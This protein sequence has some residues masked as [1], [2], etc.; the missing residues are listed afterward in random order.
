MSA[1]IDRRLAL[2]G[3]ACA[4]AA[5]PLPAGARDAASQ[6]ISEMVRTMAER[7]AARSYAPPLP[8][9]ERDALKGLAYDQYRDIRF[10]PSAALWR[11]DAIGH[12]VQFFPLGWLYEQPVE[13]KVV[14]KGEIVP[15]RASADLFDIG[16]L[17]AAA[18]EPATRGFSGFRLHAALNRP[19]YLDEYLVF[20]GA[21]YLRAVAR[22]QSYGLS[23]R[24]LSID[25]AR[26]SGEEFPAFRAFWIEKP[27]RGSDAVVVHALLDSPSVTGAYTFLV[28]P[29]A[30]TTMDVTASLFARRPLEHVGIAPLTSMYLHGP[31]QRR[32]A[33][34]FRPAV[35]DSDGLAILGGTGEQVWRPLVNPRT[36]QA[37]AFTATDPRGF[38]LMQRERRFR[39]FEDIEARYD[40]R[41]S[42]WVEPI[43]NWGPGSVDLIEIPTEEEIHDN[44]AVAWR[45]HAPLLPGAPRTYAYRLHWTSTQPGPAPVMVVNRTLTGGGK[46]GPRF[47]IDFGGKWSSELPRLD[48]K[49]SAGTVTHPVLQPLPDGDGMR[50]TFVLATG[51]AALSEL[52]AVLTSGG[53]QVSETWLYRWTR[54]G[55]A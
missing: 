11:P 29:G 23:A 1:Q 14:D 46:G 37:S 35:H 33:N 27:A 17:A 8:L 39:A 30:T 49:A 42:C 5:G 50:A 54:S 48:V 44:I 40:L 24:G 15:V 45:P 9:P 55:T 3:M 38:G 16:S 51:S 28:R 41:P 25:T 20:Q 52:R 36:L 12:E 31:A 6:S 10:R 4:A 26:P 47:V 43:G 34:D 22:G 21:S 13:I 32:I 53:R 7:A 18:G 19:D 2:A